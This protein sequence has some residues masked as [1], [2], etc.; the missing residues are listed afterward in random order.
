[1]IT[2]AE[3]KEFER[4]LE[5]ARRL[6]GSGR[7]LEELEVGSFEVADLYRAAWVQAVSALDRW[8][9]EGRPPSR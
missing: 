7:Q 8:V 2:K 3:F 1:M 4:N 9:K 5:F 6:V